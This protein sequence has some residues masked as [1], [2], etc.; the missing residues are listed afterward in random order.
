MRKYSQNWQFFIKSV[1]KKSCQKLTY[2]ILAELMD[3]WM[4]SSMDGWMS[5]GCLDG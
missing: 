4:D 5:D 3:R 2:G 1:V